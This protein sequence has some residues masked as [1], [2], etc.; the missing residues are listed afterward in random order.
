MKQP[1]NRPPFGNTGE[2][3][4]GDYNAGN[5]NAG[6][7]CT[8]D[9]NA[10]GGN[11]GS[12]NVGYKNTG[13]RNRGN[14]NVGDYNRGDCNAGSHN[15]GNRNVGSYNTGDRNV[16]HWNSGSFNAGDWNSGNF[17]A[18][19][20]NTEEPKMTLF[21]KPS[22]WS[23]ADWMLSDA[24]GILNTIPKYVLDWVPEPK[25]STAEREANPKYLVNGGYLKVLNEAECAQHWWDHL[26]EEKRKI[27]MSIPNFDAAIFY[28]CT[29][30]R[31]EPE[32]TINED[33]IE[34]WRNSNKG[35]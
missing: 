28:E 5:Y 8:G 13:D 23:Y 34:R 7:L 33:G 10:G 29:G 30:I 26:S 24:R 11:A 1:D 32:V 4:D 35:R 31:V 21:N 18:G 3:N 16:G 19:C 6:H 17:N 27:I 9:H 14:G 20:F 15:I 22:D 12:Y 2:G 25:M